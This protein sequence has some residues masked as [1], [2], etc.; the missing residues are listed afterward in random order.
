M[1]VDRSLGRQGTTHKPHGDDDFAP[2][3]PPTRRWLWVSVITMSL[4]LARDSARARSDCRCYDPP[5][6][7]T[8]NAPSCAS[9]SGA[10]PPSAAAKDRP[11]QQ[12]ANRSAVLV[13]I[14]RAT[15]PRR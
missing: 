7:G 2:S 8:E 11:L 15:T 12:L 9:I 4:C 1:T 10:A 5:V 13:G 14:H 6:A 3:G